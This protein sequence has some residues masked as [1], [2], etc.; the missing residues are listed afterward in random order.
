[1]YFNGRVQKFLWNGV[2]T[3]DAALLLLMLF[4]F[5]CCGLSE[6]RFWRV[7]RLVLVV[8]KGQFPGTLLGLFDLTGRCHDDGCCSGAAE[9]VIYSIVGVV[10]LHSHIPIYSI[11]I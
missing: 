2:L 5:L 10:V 7:L 6:W 1:M 11:R 3:H 8:T 9:C 4:T